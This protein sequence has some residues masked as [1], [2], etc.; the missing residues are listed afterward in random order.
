MHPLP[1]KFEFHAPPL[2]FKHELI[3]N[4]FVAVDFK[5]S[6]DQKASHTATKKNKILGDVAHTTYF[7]ID[8]CY[9]TLPMWK[10]LCSNRKRYHRPQPKFALVEL[11]VKK[12]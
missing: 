3:R 5:L 12:K 2:S 6:W 11:F 1:I 9:D 8:L 4:I 7:E 10:V